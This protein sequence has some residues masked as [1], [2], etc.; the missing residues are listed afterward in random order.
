M[1]INKLAKQISQQIELLKRLLKNEHTSKDSQPS[2]VAQVPRDIGE[3]DFG[4]LHYF[5][6]LRFRPQKESFPNECLSC[7]KLVDCLKHEG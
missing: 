7:Q 3:R 1:E 2:I 5:G 6:Y 4:C